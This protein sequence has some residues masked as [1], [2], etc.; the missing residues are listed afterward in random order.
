MS[1]EKQ[2]DM[3]PADDAT[4]VCDSIETWRNPDMSLTGPELVDHWDDQGWWDK[5]ADDEAHL[6]L[7][8]GEPML[9]P[10]QD[11]FI[12][13]VAAMLTASKSGRP[14]TEVE[15]N[16]TIV[17]KEHVRN[18]IDLYNVSLKLSNSGM[19]EEVRLVDEALAF[20]ADNKDSVFKFVVSRKED[21]DEID[22]IVDEWSI[23]DERVTLMPAGSSRDQLEVTYPDVAE[24]CK[25]RGWRFSPRLHVNIWDLATGV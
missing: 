11:Q 24:L 7:T 15:T 9:E 19:S 10:R 16:G 6:I 12:D 2:E 23:P 22:E 5:L 4:W 17:P 20:H 18:Y 8:G 14:F 25:Q 1:I 21:V 13:I 3:Y